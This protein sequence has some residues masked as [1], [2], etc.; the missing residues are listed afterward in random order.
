M[1]RSMW[2]TLTMLLVV[3]LAGWAVAM[4]LRTPRG[5]PDPQAEWEH[6]L[7]ASGLRP[8]LP[9]TRQVVELIEALDRGP[10]EVDRAAMG[11]AG[12]G[13]PLVVAR[14]VDGATLIAAR[15]QGPVPT[16]AASTVV[17]DWQVTLTT[18]PL[19]MAWDDA[20]WLRNGPA[21]AR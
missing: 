1:L 5:G 10:A 9:R 4:A 14:L 12:D 17:Q 3:V 21:I 19:A 7:E 2:S 6:W 15:R 8:V 11:R 16:D 20:T 18:R 13:V